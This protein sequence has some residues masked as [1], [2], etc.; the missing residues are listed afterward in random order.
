MSM[1]PS[2]AWSV[3]T[4]VLMIPVVIGVATIFFDVPPSLKVVVVVAMI[5]LVFFGTRLLFHRKGGWR[6][7]DTLGKQMP[8][9]DH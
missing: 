4:T 1:S 5:A 2:Q 8:A 6:P 9:D 7:S 3:G